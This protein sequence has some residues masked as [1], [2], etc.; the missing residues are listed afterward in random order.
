[1]TFKATAVNCDL[2]AL[3]RWRDEMADLIETAP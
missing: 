2:A 3:Y 1:M